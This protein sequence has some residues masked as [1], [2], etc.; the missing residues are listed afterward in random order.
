MAERQPMHIRSLR[1]QE[2]K[3]MTSESSSPPHLFALR[4]SDLEGNILTPSSPAESLSHP[5]MLSGTITPARTLREAGLHLTSATSALSSIGSTRMP[6]HSQ[7][8]VLTSSS[9]ASS[10]V[11]ALGKDRAPLA[12]RQYLLGELVN[13][14]RHLSI[15][16]RSSILQSSPASPEPPQPLPTMSIRPA[17]LH[18]FGDESLGGPVLPEL[19]EMNGTLSPVCSR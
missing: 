4:P 6:S 1:M 11:S 7:E 2:S 12:A 16:E 18:A 19:P 5:Q 8:L 15:S 3:G 13:L 17:D 10:T 14:L 9:T